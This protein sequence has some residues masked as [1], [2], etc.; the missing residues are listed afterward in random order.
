MRVA[1]V[2][3]SFDPPHLAHVQVVLHLLKS[4]RFDEVWIVPSPQ[5]PL[6]PASTPFEDRLT[7]CRLAFED[8]DPRVHVREDEGSLSGYT[9]DLIRHLKQ[10]FPQAHFTFVGGSDLAEEIP[11]W[12]ES[13]A[14][15]KLLSFE[16][17]PRPPDP[18]SPFS[19]TSATEIRERIKK[20]LPTETLVPKP[21]LAFLRNHKLYQ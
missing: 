1:L 15:Q 19:P 8:I 20:G 5:N 17:L 13:E 2:G 12:K 21:V 18:A 9:I 6:K 16:F 7:M 4:G 10:H 3:G 11:R 14:L